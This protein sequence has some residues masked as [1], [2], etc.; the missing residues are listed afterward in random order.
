MTALTGAAS[1]IADAAA[2]CRPRPGNKAILLGISG[3]DASGKSTLARRVGD[4]LRRRGMPFAP[5]SIDWFH[6]DAGTRFLPPARANEPPASHAEH[7]FHH[8]FRWSELFRGLVGPL[9]AT[10]ACDQTVGVHDMKTDQIMPTH[11]RH[12]G[13]RIVLLEGI[14]I[15]RHEHAPLFDLRVWLDCSFETAMVRAVSRNQESL[16]EAAIRADYERVY[17]PAQRLHLRRDNPTKGA[18]IVPEAP[19]P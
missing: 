17:F 2:A 9:L 3:I 8:A 12:S 1:R 13:V 16:P 11:V 18:L 6:T 15:F 7:F 10:G 14:F 5:L 4:E 19:S